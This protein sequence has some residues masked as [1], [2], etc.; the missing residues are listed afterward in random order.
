MTNLALNAG[1]VNPLRGAGNC[2]TGHNEPAAAVSQN[3]PFW[4]A[5][6]QPF[7]APVNMPFL[8]CRCTNGEATATGINAITITA[9]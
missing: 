2:A 4:M 5:N 6:G 8:K 9:I 1:K 3:H 7:T